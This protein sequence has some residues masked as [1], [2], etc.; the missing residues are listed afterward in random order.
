MKLKQMDDQ[1][2]GNWSFTF[3]ISET[4]VVYYRGKRQPYGI[5]TN[6]HQYNFLE[7]QIQKVNHFKS[8]IWW[9]YELHEAGIHYPPRLHIHGYVLNTTEAEMEHFRNN[10]YGNPIQIGYSGIIKL[11]KMERTYYDKFFW[12]KYCEKHQKDIIYYMGGLEQKKMTKDLNGEK[13][14]VLID[15]GIDAHYFNSLEEHLEE[16]DIG[17]DYN[18]GKLNKFVVEI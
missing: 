5:L 4:K 6:E 18:Y 3:T 1:T 12:E 7:K 11:S 16:R 9:V 14:K 10:F 2:R 8:N 17:R 15:T 13:F